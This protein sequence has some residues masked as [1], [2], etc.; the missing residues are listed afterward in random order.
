MLYDISYQHYRSRLFAAALIA[1]HRVHIVRSVCVFAA[2]KSILG[3]KW[4][5]LKGRYS[6]I[7]FTTVCSN[8][9]G[10]VGQCIAIRALGTS[11]LACLPLAQACSRLDRHSVRL[12]RA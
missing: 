2:T 3:N 4:Y 8:V 10:Y 9:S 6:V 11:I 1:S 7:R 12:R 5:A